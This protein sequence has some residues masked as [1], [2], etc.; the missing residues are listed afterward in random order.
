MK[1]I[2]FILVLTGLI[3]ICGYDYFS[4]ATSRYNL[5]Q[6]VAKTKLNLC[7]VPEVDPFDKTNKKEEKKGRY[8]PPVGFDKELNIEWQ[9]TRPLT[10]G[11]Y[12]D[13]DQKLWWRPIPIVQP[14]QSRQPVTRWTEYDS[15]GNCVGGNC[16]V[17][18][19]RQ[20][21]Q[22]IPQENCPSGNCPTRR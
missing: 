15:N 1:K 14:T 18:Q 8:R 4:Q 11:W 7:S 19:G 22:S 16:Q 5:C 17:P 13:E 12:L 6:K 9:D 10:P 3:C 20:I 21:I 2:I